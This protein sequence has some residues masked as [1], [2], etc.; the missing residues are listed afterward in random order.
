M[1]QLFLM[2]I[3]AVTLHLI[4]GWPLLIGLLI[5]TAILVVPGLIKLLSQANNENRNVVFGIALQVIGGTIIAAIIAYVVV[6]LG[7]F[8]TGR[9]PS[10]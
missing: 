9:H 10:W 8:G 6:V 4:L 2:V 5:G 1:P 7:T 3:V